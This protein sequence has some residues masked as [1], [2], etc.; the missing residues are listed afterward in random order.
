MAIAM[1][2]HGGLGV[3]HRYNTIEDQVAIVREVRTKTDKVAAAI[4]VSGDFLER[5]QSVVSEGASILCVDV[6]HGHHVLM[7]RALKTLRDHFGTGVSIIAGNVATVEAFEDLQAWGASAIRVGVGGGSICS[8]RIQTG[9]GVSTFQSVIACSFA[10]RNA[11]LIADGGIRNSGDIVKSI[12]AGAD[13][14]MLGSL[15]AGT[16]EAPGD[17]LT[18]T[19]GRRYKVYRGMASS[20][21]QI[22]WRGEARSLEGIT[23]TANYRGSVSDV[24]QKLALNIKSG[25]SYSGARNQSELRENSTFVQQSSSSRIESSTHILLKNG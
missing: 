5:A 10:K 25:F 9:H 12:A 19:T 18:D 1:A 8:T 3:I 16:D 14:V 23:A 22:D 15:L 21:A 11:I 20:E 13:M 6:A 2:K 7:E 4:G 17:T 24:L